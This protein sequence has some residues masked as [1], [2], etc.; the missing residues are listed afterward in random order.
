VGSRGVAA[1]ASNAFPEGG[2]NRAILGNLSSE[3]HFSR[4]LRKFKVR[5]LSGAGP[6]LDP[7]KI[8]PLILT[9][10]KGFCYSIAR[11]AIANKRSR[12]VFEAKIL[13]QLM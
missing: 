9:R 8:H 12:A 7:S 1:N 5:D 3:D 11:W 10:R 6:D 2:L 13:H 4:F